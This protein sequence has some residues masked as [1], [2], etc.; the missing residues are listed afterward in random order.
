MYHLTPKYILE[1]LAA[2]FQMK[3]TKLIT[4]AA[5]EWQRPERNDCTQR[6]LA[7]ALAAFHFPAKGQEYATKLKITPR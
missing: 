3:F 2:S 7:L 4:R 6:A 5:A 1:A